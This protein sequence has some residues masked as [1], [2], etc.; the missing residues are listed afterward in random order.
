VKAAYITVSL[1][2]NSNQGMLGISVTDDN[3]V[4]GDWNTVRETKGTK[5][6][7]LTYTGAPSV[8]NQWK[9]GYLD[10][11][12]RDLMQASFG[13]N[14]NQ[15]QFFH[16]CYDSKNSSTE[17]AIDAVVNITYDV[18]VCELKDLGQS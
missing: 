12:Q 8:T 2:S 4:N 7:P 10:P 13:A 6:I 3:V 15:V 11:S 17:S 18:D 9:A 5:Y 16:I 14:P 1:V